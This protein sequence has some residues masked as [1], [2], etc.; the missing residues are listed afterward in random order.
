MKKVVL[1]VDGM[2]CSACS[3]GLEKYLNKQNGVYGAS[4]N[5]IMNNVEI[6]YNEEVLIMEDLEKFISKAGFKSLGIDSF[7]KEEKVN[8]FKVIEIILLSIFFV[9]AFLVHLLGYFNDNINHNIVGI[10]LLV[11]SIIC[12]VLGKDILINGFKSV[13]LLNPGMDSLVSL[14]VICAFLYS[15]YLLI[16]NINGESNTLYFTS[17][18]MVIFF[19][20]VGKFIESKTM[21]MTKKAISDLMLLTPSY[22]K[23]KEN[24]SIKKVTI[25]E[26]EVDDILVSSSGDS[27]AVDGEIVSGY[28]TINESLITGE[29]LPKDKNIGSEVI[30]GSVVT[31]GYIEYKAKRIGKDSTVSE[32][33]RMIVASSKSKSKINKISDAL[34]KYFVYLI[35]I[36][37][38]LGFVTWLIISK[39]FATAFKVFLTVLVVA[40]PCSL[41][42]ATPIALVVSSGT[43]AKRGI[44]VKN[45]S[46]YEILPKVKNVV[47]DKTGT[48]TYGNL[49]IDE[50][51]YF[52]DDVFNYLYSLETKSSHPIAKCIVKVEKDD[53]KLYDV[54]EFRET[55][56][57]GIEG[58]INDINVRVGNLAFLEDAQVS[59]EYKRKNRIIL[60]IAFDTELVGFVTLKDKVR[61]D[62]KDLIDLLKKD[63]IKTILLSGDNL[64]SCL[65]I[66]SE[67]NLDEVKAGYLPIEKANYL[68]ELKKSGVTLMVGD[69]INDAISLDISDVGISLSGASSIAINS[70]SC[71]IMNDNLLSIATLINFSKKTYKIIKE[72]VIWAFSYNIIMIL[73]ALGV[74]SPI[75][76]TINPIIASILMMVS[77]ITV[78]VNALRLRRIK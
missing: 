49:E 6:E 20:R 5:L 47:F 18:I 53:K 26:V 7:K 62:S 31:N 48:L 69:G 1:K 41:G 27:I 37:A 11:V 17:T 60:Y 68:K 28:A 13:R 33:V 75:G 74:L 42:L 9:L 19:V 38:F 65:D 71:V 36:L 35:L 50:E 52:K 55:S 57:K 2:S 54:K 66:N 29:N 8:K 61:S 58:I 22:A 39:S 15:I 64:D 76:I 59:Q 32:I 44:L 23:K 46:I 16:K 10:I 14:S 3:N 51:V 34:S 70:A 25:D 4:V 73:I 40:C 72:N 21:M 30:A 67:L 12:L 63:N 77:S 56:G 78:I 45:N 24:D 43:C